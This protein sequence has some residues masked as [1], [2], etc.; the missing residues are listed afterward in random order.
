MSKR[1]VLA[2]L[3]DKNIVTTRVEYCRGCPVPGGYASG[4]DIDLSDEVVDAIYYKE[5][6]C[7]VSNFL[8]F[9]SLEQVMGW[10]ETL[11]K[12]PA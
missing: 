11:P 1:K 4:W 2:A 12:L 9:D 5:P 10:I 6:E 3:K 7:A 8:E